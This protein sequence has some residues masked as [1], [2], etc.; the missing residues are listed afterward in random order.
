MLIGQIILSVPMKTLIIVM[1]VCATKITIDESL[2][3]FLLSDIEEKQ[4]IASS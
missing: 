1:R 4:F 3:N 2:T